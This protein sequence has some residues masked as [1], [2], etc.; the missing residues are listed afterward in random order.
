VKHSDHNDHV[1]VDAIEQ[2]IRESAKRRAPD[3]PV[4]DLIRLW[5]LSDETSRYRG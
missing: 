2:T 1:R 4:K 5:M 3:T